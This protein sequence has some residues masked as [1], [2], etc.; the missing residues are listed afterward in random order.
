M[1]E[2]Y[3]EA[4][5]V[6]T[7]KLQYQRGEKEVKFAG[8]KDW[9]EERGRSWRGK[10]GD[11][12]RGWLTL[13]G[14]N[15]WYP[16]VGSIPGQI[17]GAGSVEIGSLGLA[18][19]FHGISRVVLTWPCCPDCTVCGLSLFLSILTCDPSTGITQI[20]SKGLLS[21]RFESAVAERA[22]EPGLGS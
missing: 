1:E 13:I 12:G 2:G 3:S 16:S 7:E 5:S 4:L 10:K 8:D 15:L 22:F 14:T 21:S 18:Q 11:L 17:P 20:C 6:V 9:W 19:S